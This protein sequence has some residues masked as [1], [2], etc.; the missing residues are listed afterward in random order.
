VKMLCYGSLNLD[1]I[2]RVRRF[3]QPG[4]SV[5]ALTFQLGCGGK[6]LNISLA[7][8]AAGC[9]VWHAGK[10]GPDGAMLIERLIRAGVDTTLISTSGS[11]TGHAIIQIDE[12]GQNQVMVAAGAN[13]ELTPAECAAA[14]E[15]FSAGDWLLL[16]NE[17]NCLAQLLEL[18]QKR[19]MVIAFNPSP[20]DENLRRLDL[21]AVSYLI[22]NYPTGCLMT[23][24]TVPEDICQALLAR[25]PEA[26]IT[27]TLGEQGCLYFTAQEHLAQHGYPAK[28]V[29]PTGAGDVFTGYFLAGLARGAK[30]ER[31]L[32]SATKAAALSVGHSGAAEYVPTPA[33][34]ESAYRL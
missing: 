32:R 16:Q 14:V 7:A 2:Y 15:Q 17:T 25:Y 11:A 8:A 9:E 21:S 29:D 27:L 4:E 18:G 33:E 34:V 22:L 20:A 1:R 31:A 28:V 12:N 26:H 24:R 19:G 6:G 5:P 30:V 23:G 10:V 13:H 3:G